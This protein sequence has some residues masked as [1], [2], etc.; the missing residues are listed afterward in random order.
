[1]S[2]QSWQGS[3]DKTR[4]LTEKLGAA[5]PTHIFWEQK[6]V[7]DKL[8]KEGLLCSAFRDPT[9]LIVP[10][11]FANSAVW[12]GI[13]GTMYSRKLYFCN[14]YLKCKVQKFHTLGS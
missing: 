14:N 12:T 4:L 7:S 9:F 11:M 1:M 6:K 5:M 10:P 3:C 13:S 8:S 2:T